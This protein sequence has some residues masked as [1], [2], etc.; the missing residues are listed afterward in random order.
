MKIKY[1][2]ALMTVIATAG[3]CTQDTGEQPEEAVPIRLAA[4]IAPTDAGKTRAFGV[5]GGAA[6][7]QDTE[8]LTGQT[9]RAWISENDG[10]H[11]AAIKDPIEYTVSNAAGD[12]EPVNTTTDPAFYYPQGVDVISIHAIHPSGYASGGTFTVNTDQ[13][14]EANYAASDLCYSMPANFARTDVDANGRKLLQMK[15][16]LSKIVV[17]LTLDP[18]VTSATLPTS[19]KLHAKTSTTMTFPVA[20]STDANCYTGCTA[21]DASNPGI[22]TMIQE[23]IIPPQ[24]IAAG[25]SVLSFSVTGIGPMIYPMPAATT[26]ESG[27]RYIYDIRVKNVGIDVT[28]TVTDWDRNDETQNNIIR[29]Q[30]LDLIKNL[31]LY[32]VDE[33][34]VITTSSS[35]LTTDFMLASNLN[36]GYFWQWNSAASDGG[37]LYAPSYFGPTSGF[38]PSSNYDSYYTRPDA[39]NLPGHHLPILSEWLSIAP[40]ISDN[41]FGYAPTLNTGVLKSNYITPKWGT[42]ETTKAGVS[43][44]SYFYPTNNTN[45]SRVLWAVRFLGTD[46]CSIWKYQQR[47]GWT[48]SD[49]G[50][51]T[52]SAKWLDKEIYTTSYVQSNMATIINNISWGDLTE[53]DLTG[54]D[55]VHFVC[56]RTFY[57]L[58]WA[59]GV[60]LGSATANGAQGEAPCYWSATRNASDQAH[61]FCT[62]S[63]SSDVFHTTKLSSFNIRLF[64]DN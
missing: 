29:A 18:N 48:A 25:A 37:T 57:A 13:T 10:L 41:L 8:L 59:T 56:R 17:N 4:T 16:L 36:E 50:Y 3:G 62:Y 35:N 21:S 30:Q 44:T 47:G 27:K 38:N 31:P 14:T 5:W 40:S 60:T 1:I 11:T 64:R 7:T 43:E 55:V 39:T 28:T 20:S 53:S 15:H 33:Y 49:Y 34:N 54:D 23:A 46:Y 58:G 32:Y 51:V 52:I 61:R 63:S 24:T 2:V 9:V 45:G 22:I 19:I 12:L 6:T 42:N 26:F